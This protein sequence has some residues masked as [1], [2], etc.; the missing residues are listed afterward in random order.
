[1]DDGCK[2]GK[3]L[4]LSTNSFKYKDLL[5]LVKIL[6]DKYNLKSTIQKTGKIDQ[7][8]IYIRSES[9]PNLVKIVKP[10]IISSMKYK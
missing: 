9:M 1:M 2:L 7:Y 4:K 10:Y 3:G 6:K 5:Y 8:N